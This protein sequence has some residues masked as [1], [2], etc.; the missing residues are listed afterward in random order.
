M[1]RA[2]RRAGR[3]VAAGAIA[4]IVLSPASTAGAATFTHR[5]VVT[6]DHT[7]VPDADPLPLTKRIR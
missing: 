7:R 1:T 2:G 5:T 4:A 3:A 6:I